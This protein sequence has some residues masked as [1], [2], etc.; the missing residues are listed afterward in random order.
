MRTASPTSAS[1][2]SSVWPGSAY[3][4][5]MFTVPKISSAAADRAPRL[6]GAVDA[7]ERREQRVVE[8]LHAERQAVHARGAIAAEALRLERAG[9]RFQRDLGV[10]IDRQARAHRGEQPSMAAGENRLGVP[11][12]MKIVCSCR[13]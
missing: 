11:P 5:S 2:S 9:I 6:V 12:P 8:A 1:A 13:P 7:P 3:I 10:G 4:R